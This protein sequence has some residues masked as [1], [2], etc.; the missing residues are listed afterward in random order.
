MRVN[1]V[2]LKQAGEAEPKSIWDNKVSIQR[3]DGGAPI[4]AGWRVVRLCYGPEV[5]ADLH[6]P[7]GLAKGSRWRDVGMVR[8]ETARGME[9]RMGEEKEEEEQ[10]DVAQLMICCYLCMHGADVDACSVETRLGEF[11][12]RRIPGSTRS[13]AHVPMCVPCLAVSTQRCI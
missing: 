5:T 2:V 12:R 13:T 3:T 1:K 4:W 7:F 6:Q 10:G 8:L 11:P 9:G